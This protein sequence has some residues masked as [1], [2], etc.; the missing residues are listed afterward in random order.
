MSPYTIYSAMAAVQTTTLDTSDINC[1]HFV[2]YD[3]S[4]VLIYCWKMAKKPVLKK[5][6]G[7]VHTQESIS[8]ISLPGSH[9]G[10]PPPPPPLRSAIKEYTDKYG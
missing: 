8:C 4:T 3:Y 5:K 2:C 7:G 9:G 10:D 1:R 6:Y